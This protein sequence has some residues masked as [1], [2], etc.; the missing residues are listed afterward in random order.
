MPVGVLYRRCVVDARPLVRQFWT[1]KPADCFLQRL[2]CRYY[3]PSDIQRDF[4][5]IENYQAP[6]A[7]HPS[8]IMSVSNTGG[9]G[10]GDQRG[11]IIG[12]VI[13]HGKHEFWGKPG[14]H[15]HQGMK[16]GENTLNALCARLMTRTI[17]K[18]HGY[19]PKPALDAY[20]Q[21]MTTPGSHN[22]T[23]AESFHRDF[24]V[25]WAKGVP[26]EKCAGPEGHNTAQIGGFVMLPPVILSQIGKDGA[27]A[28]EMALKHLALTHNSD[29]LKKFA[30]T[31]ADLIYSLTRDGPGTTESFRAKLSE[32][33]S[34]SLKLDLNKVISANY[35]DV[36]AIH[37]VFGSACYI[38]SSFPAC[39][40]LS[41]KYADSFEKAILANTN[42]GGENCHRGSALGA[43]MGAALG[44]KA[45]P[46]RFRD[47][48]HDSA[49]IK[50]EIDAFV[51]QVA[52]EHS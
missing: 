11:R 44:E 12:D 8:S 24:F 43:L 34:K 18:A 19:D 30:G 36:G 35:A 26:P 2:L 33:A 39:L 28:R 9:H 48:L 45:I 13:N 6:K 1:S 5:T 41:Y 32:I 16:A 10:R 31:F 20:V 15:Y 7:R 21:F 46:Q 38:D 47:G 22:D 25:N 14:V 42:V 17:T 27:V 37:S 3:N 40:Y 4:G 49:A 50:D 52:S 23:Y 29:K 51:A